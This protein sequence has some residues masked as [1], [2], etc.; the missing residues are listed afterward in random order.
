MNSR[1]ITPL[2]FDLLLEQYRTSVKNGNIVE[3][4]WELSIDTQN[5]LIERATIR[6][7]TP[8]E[9]ANI[10]VAHSVYYEL[11]GI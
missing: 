6:G 8:E 10:Y 1:H 5:Q 2:E 7:V 3:V 9:L 4:D 11:R